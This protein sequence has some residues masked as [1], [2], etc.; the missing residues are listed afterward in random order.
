M[1]KKEILDRKLI[2]V[3]TVT[4]R[5]SQ[6][7]HITDEYVKK[8][9]NHRYTKIYDDKIQRDLY[10]AFLIK[11]SNQENTH[12]D[13]NK[14]LQTY[15]SFKIQHDKCISNLLT[16]SHKYPTSMGLKHFCN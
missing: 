2:E 3:N 6:Y 13:R 11:N 1:G 15:D 12:A 5:A 9:L 14:C 8:K 7:N 16:Q 10:S 4:F